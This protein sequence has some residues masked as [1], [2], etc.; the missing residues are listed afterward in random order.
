VYDVSNVTT[1][2]SW[3][4]GNFQWWLVVLMVL[5]ATSSSLFGA[6]GL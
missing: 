2:T 4:L 3:T 1:L 5:N 6:N